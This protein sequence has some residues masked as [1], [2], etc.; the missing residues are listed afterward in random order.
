MLGDIVADVVMGVDNE[1]TRSFVWRENPMGKTVY[2]P[3]GD[4]ILAENSF[5][6]IVGERG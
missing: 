6:R 1:E 2:M 3:N 5:V 4:G